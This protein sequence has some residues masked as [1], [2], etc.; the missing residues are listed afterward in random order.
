MAKRVQIA[1]ASNGTYY[2]LPGNSAELSNE[3]GELTD[4]I[5]GQ[6]YQSTESGIGSWSLKTNALIKGFAGYIVSI[7]KTGISTAMVDEAM[8]LVSGK[9]YRITAAAKRIIDWNTAYTVKG[10]AVAIADSN[11]QSI[12]FLTGEVTFISSYT[13]TTPITISGSYLPTSEVAGAKQFTLTMTADATDTTD[14]PTAKTNGGYK[15]FQSGLNT[16]ALEL[17]GI[18]KSANG[19]AAA[20]ASRSPVIIEINPDNAGKAIARGIFKMVT[21][22]QSGDVGALEE[23]TVNFN[24][25]VPDVQKMVTPFT[26]IIDATSTINVG[27]QNLINGW[28]NKTSVFAKYLPDGS[29]GFSGEAIVTEV[30]LGGGLE[31]MNEFSCTLR[32][33]GATTTV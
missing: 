21:Q 20:L 17:S 11:I 26:W 18:Y 25:H 27:V 28:L 32:G 30:S 31:A 23:E 7:K 14:I 13:P 22:N 33:T 2:T 12:N 16:A 15:T 3:N 29:T 24:L 4:T 10:N 9:T 1:S 5:Y 8:A 19:N 6:E